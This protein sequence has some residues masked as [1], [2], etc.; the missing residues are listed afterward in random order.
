MIENGFKFPYPLEVNE[1][2]Y[3]YSVCNYCNDCW[4]S[5]PSRGNWG[6][7]PSIG[8]LVSITGKRFRPL[9]GWMGGITEITLENIY[10]MLRFRP[11]P[12]WLGFL[13][14]KAMFQKASIKKFSSPP[15]VT[16]VSYLS[17]EFGLYRRCCI[18]S[19]P[20]RGNWGVLQYDQWTT[21]PKQRNVSVPSQ[22]D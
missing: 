9:S 12:R 19:V 2:S 20:F 13:T 5:V 14:E 8:L 17:Q 18:V 10:T 7:L 15:E 11:L 16:G 4:V 3:H 1:G 6:L 22:D 21:K